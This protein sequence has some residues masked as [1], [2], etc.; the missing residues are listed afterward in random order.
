MVLENTAQKTSGNEKWSTSLPMPHVIFHSVQP[1]LFADEHCRLW[2]SSRVTHVW[3][4]SIG[5]VSKQGDVCFT[6]CQCSCIVTGSS[7][8]T[9]A[10]SLHACMRAHMPI[11]A[12]IEDL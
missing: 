6:S 3:C 9:Q 1:G 4:L 7:P 2:N 8:L 10:L 5:S 11:S 12:E